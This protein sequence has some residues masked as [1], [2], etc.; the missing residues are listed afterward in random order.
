MRGSPSYQQVPKVHV[1][2]LHLGAE[3]NE[4]C[5]YQS[6]HFHCTVPV[7]AFKRFAQRRYRQQERASSF[8]RLSNKT[9][10]TAVKTDINVKTFTLRAW[11]APTLDI[12]AALQKK[13]TQGKMWNY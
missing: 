2:Q 13:Q 6:T 7:C 5:P 9:Q 11:L 12:Q 1:G 8:V 10:R 3:H 4:M